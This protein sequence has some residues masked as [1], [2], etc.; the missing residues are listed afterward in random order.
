MLIISSKHKAT[1]KVDV[2]LLDDHISRKD[3][4]TQFFNKA[5]ELKEKVRKR[6]DDSYVISLIEMSTY[7]IIV[8][9]L[10][11]NLTGWGEPPYRDNIGLRYLGGKGW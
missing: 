8:C 1:G 4:Q 6:K 9:E 2:M 3:A 5:V 10:A 7:R 11:T